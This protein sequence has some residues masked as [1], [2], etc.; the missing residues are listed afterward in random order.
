DQQQ[1]AVADQQVGRLDVAVGQ[2]SF[3]ELAD[4]LEAVVDHLLGDLGL[5]ELDRVGEELGD[6]QVLAFGGELDHAVGSGA[7]QVGV[8]AQPQ[9]VVLL[10]DQPA[11]GV[12]RLL[13][14]Q[15]AVQQLP[16]ELVP[17]VGPQVTAGVQ[18]AEQLSG[19][20]PFDGDPQGGG[21]GRPRQAERLDL[22]DGQAELVPPPAP[23]GG[24]PGPGDVEV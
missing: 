16:A 2:P 1:V 6:Q 4:N 15:P 11:H 13:V 10:L 8:A 20:L 23:E 12:E 14:L 9:G 7:G 18:L 21:A 5:A 24:A 22:G 17:A 19:R 3:P